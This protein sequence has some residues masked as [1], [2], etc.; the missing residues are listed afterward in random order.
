MNVFTL[1]VVESRS[2]VLAEVGMYSSVAS[3]VV[4][5]SALTVKDGFR[6]NL[7]QKASAL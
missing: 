5:P 7:L 2:A 1:A 6:L 3:V 4:V